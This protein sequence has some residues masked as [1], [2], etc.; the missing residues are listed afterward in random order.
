VVAVVPVQ[1]EAVPIY[2]YVGQSE[3]RLEMADGTTVALAISDEMRLAIKNFKEDMYK[4]FQQVSREETP[5][6]DGEGRAIVKKRPDGYNY[7][8]ASYMFDRLSKHFPGWSL[9]M[10]APLDFHGAEWVTAQVNLIVIDYG[11]LAQGMPLEHCKRKFYGVDSLRIQYGKDKEHKP[12]NLVDLGDN[13][14]SA[15]TAAG[16]WAINRLLGI[17]DDV[18]GK[19]IEEEGAGSLETVLET[20]GDAVT[21]G[22]LVA[23]HKISYNEIFEILGVKGLSEITNFTEA[24]GKIKEAKGL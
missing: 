9:E 11:L 22:K 7:I 23:Q 5:V 8:I 12:E 20:R 18:Y 17:G 10:A 3:R 21:F 6:L 13:C 4:E 15:I 2:R 16:K 19:R 14:K 1:Q 24:W